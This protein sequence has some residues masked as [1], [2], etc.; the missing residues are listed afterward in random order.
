MVSPRAWWNAMSSLRDPLGLAEPRVE[1]VVD[2]GP[3]GA[4]VAELPRVA[5]LEIPLGEQEGEAGI[6]CRVVDVEHDGARA[7]VGEARLELAEGDRAAG[8]RGRDRGRCSLVRTREAGQQQTDGADPP[9]HK[10]SHG[11]VLA[12]DDETWGPPRPFEWGGRAAGAPSRLE[13][14]LAS[15]IAGGRLDPR[16]VSR[17]SPYGRKSRC[18]AANFKRP[19]N[20]C[21]LPN[22]LLRRIAATPPLAS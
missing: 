11:A 18:V 17:R 4:V 8:N 19:R 12:F 6:E 10:A 2:E 1:T 21:G 16:S 7:L 22:P 15:C 5:L 9:G 14:G 13:K 3:E 20:G